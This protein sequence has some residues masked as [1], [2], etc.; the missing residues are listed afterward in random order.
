MY[1]VRALLTQMIKEVLLHGLGSI[2]VASL[3]SLGYKGTSSSNHGVTTGQRQERVVQLGQTVV[4]ILPTEHRDL[5]M[6]TPP[7]PYHILCR[8]IN[9]VLPLHRPLDLLLLPG[10]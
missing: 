3:L 4:L 10:P 9:L 7:L 8:K 2:P 6:L 5:N 1:L